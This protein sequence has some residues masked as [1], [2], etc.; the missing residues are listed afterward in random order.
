MYLSQYGWLDPSAR[1]PGSAALLDVR[2]AVKDFQAFAGLNQTG[3]LDD[4]TLVLMSE[5]YRY[6]LSF[7]LAMVDLRLNLVHASHRHASMWCSGQSWSR[8]PTAK[9]TIRLAR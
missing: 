6:I 3:E 2:G 7:A 9:K 8:C 1:K 5:S 4:E